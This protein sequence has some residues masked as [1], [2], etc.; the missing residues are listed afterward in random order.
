MILEEW[1]KATGIDN[2]REYLENFEV[3]DRPDNQV[4][5]TIR[6]VT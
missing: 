3:S 2:R 4:T 5:P 6:S 1:N